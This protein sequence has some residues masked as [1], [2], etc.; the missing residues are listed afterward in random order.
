MVHLSSV[1]NVSMSM[2]G[3]VLFFPGQTIFINPLGFGA[4]LGDPSIGPTKEKP[5]LQ[6]SLSNVMGLGGYHTI[7]S[8]SNTIDRDFTTSVTALWT[9]NGTNRSRSPWNQQGNTPCSEGGE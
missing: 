6:P 9:G 3:N 7:I 4:S 5:D 1:Y 8:V 2:F